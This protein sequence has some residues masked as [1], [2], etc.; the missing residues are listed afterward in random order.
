MFTGLIQKKGKIRRVS[1]GRA[2]VMEIETDSPW[3]P[4]LS[5]GESVAVNGVCLTVARHDRTRFTADV[6]EETA[7]RSTLGSLA[8]GAE[9]NLERALRAGDRF[10]G[11]VVQ[12]HV[13]G[14]G[15][16]VSRTPKGRDFRLSFKCPRAIAA[17]TVMKGSI[18]VNG[19]SLTVSD[20]GDDRFSV[21]VIPTTVAE[22]NL[23]A[24]RPG[25]AVNLESDVLGR[26]ALRGAGAAANEDAAPQSGGLTFEK[27]AENGFI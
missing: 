26:Y 7:Q 3:I 24:L 15:T 25:D 20:I 11:H 14:T 16:L 2:R 4:E 10:G 9:V 6:L 22:T 19:V 23:G 8:P 1:Y 12:G 13:D 5:D 21:D 18:A 17:A 27:L